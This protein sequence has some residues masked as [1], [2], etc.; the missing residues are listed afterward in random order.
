[1]KKPKIAIKDLSIEQ[2]GKPIITKISLDI[3]QNEIFGILGPS[4]SGKLE[5][6]ET[7]NRLIEIEPGYRVKGQILIDGKDIFSKYTLT[8]LRKKV[9]MIFATP[10]PLPFS[11]WENVA[12]GPK[13]HGVSKD[14]I[15]TLVEESLKSCYLWDEVKERLGEPAFNLSGGQQQRLCLARCLAVEPEIL[16][17]YEPCS[18]LDPI[19]T[20]KIEN[21]MRA[22]QKKYTILLITNNIKQ[23]ARVSDR[24]AFILEGELIE[25]DKTSILFTSPKDKR[26]EDYISGKFG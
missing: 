8:E 19:S 7:L 13:L 23:V 1:M 22:L 4:K 14:K 3:Y 16:L 11:V 26:T 17:F 25:V 6:V 18:A 20:A 12:Y 9:G 2:D 5:L 21:T 15:K 24:A 10:N